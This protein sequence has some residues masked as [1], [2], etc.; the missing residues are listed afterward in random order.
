[1]Q[2]ELASGRLVPAAPA[3]TFSISMELRIYRERPE[4]SRR[5]KPAAQA[6]WDY[7]ASAA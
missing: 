4:M 6:L 2:T 1:V 5:Q 3:G 7:L